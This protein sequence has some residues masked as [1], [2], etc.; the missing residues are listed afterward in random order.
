MNEIEI[1]A[2]FLKILYEIKYEQISSININK[3]KLQTKET[4]T[5]YLTYFLKNGVL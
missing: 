4:Q 5:K 1:S 3:R 2:F